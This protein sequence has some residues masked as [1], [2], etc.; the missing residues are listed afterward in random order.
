MH[1]PR[2]FA[3]LASDYM[4][5]VID[6]GINYRYERLGLPMRLQSRV[7]NGY[8]YVA[9]R[10]LVPETELPK[11]RE[12]TTERR[13]AQSRVVRS[14]WNEKVLPTLLKTYEWMR[15]VPVET[16]SLAEV[17][18]AWNELWDRIPR[19]FGLHFMTNAGSYQSL[20]DLAD[21]YESL[22]KGIHPSEAMTL[23]AGLPN[24][25]QRVQRD[26]YLLTES[27]R[28]SPPVADLVLRDSDQALT[29][30][31]RVEG[32]PEFLNGL[33]AFL[34]AHGH[35]GQP[36]D[37]LALP[38]WKDNPSVVLDEVRKRLLQREEDPETRRLRRAAE[39]DALAEQVRTRLRDRPEELQLFENALALAR[40][41]GP[42]TEGHNYW[43]DRMLHAYVH[44]FAVRVG[45]RLVQAGVLSDPGD[46]FF[47]HAEEV[48]EAL[49]HP[50]D[51]RTLVAGRKGALHRWSAIRPPKYLGKPP[52]TSEPQGRFEPRPL[53]QTDARGLRG[54]GAC[55]GTG[56]GPARIVFLPD[57]FGRVQPGDVLVCPSSNP[58]WVPLFGIIAGLV[59]NTG[60][61]LSH[62]AVVAREFGV[63]AVVGTGEAT[64]R[65]RDGQLVEVDGTAGEVRIL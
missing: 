17:A 36:Y 38:S 4:Q 35:L 58:S 8:V 42:L 29:E 33:H 57:D 55:A 61:V 64:Q 25:L 12:Q 7:C 13:R 6:G 51:L 3:A 26:L 40:D 28:A 24:D 2:A 22:V 43:L 65:L 45:R 53:E 60:G 21:L 63:P 59:T 54:V 32:G 62:A 19:L 50:R 23:V 41:V 11:I 20:D 16:A 52:D 47:L 14:Y 27:A 18:G 48:G 49:R 46:V 30:L 10:L 31:R 44:R 15:G 37:D 56:R 39:A 34:E 5:A 9:S 1:C